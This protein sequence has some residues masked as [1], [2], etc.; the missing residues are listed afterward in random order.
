MESDGQRGLRGAYACGIAF[1]SVRPC[2]P[3]RVRPANCSSCLEPQLLPTMRVS[4][5]LVAVNLI[6]LASVRCGEASPAAGWGVTKKAAASSTPERRGC[7]RRVFSGRH[8]H[9]SST[10]AFLGR[11]PST[12]TTRGSAGSEAEA[13]GALSSAVAAEPQTVGG[14]TADVAA[15]GSRSAATAGGS[16]AAETAEPE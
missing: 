7:N 15:D 8:T 3:L 10:L 11:R 9:S 5:L 6:A 1:S 13:V 4:D 14:A 2:I 12:S 16:V